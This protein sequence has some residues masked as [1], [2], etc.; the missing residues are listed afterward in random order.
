MQGGGGVDFDQGQ[1]PGDDAA[2]AADDA[3]EVAFG[4][5]GLV[6]G[7]PILDDEWGGGVEKEIEAAEK[8]EEGHHRNKDA[9]REGMTGLGEEEMCCGC[10]GGRIR[11]WGLVRERGFSWVYG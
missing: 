1:Q 3:H 4:V 7:F 11:L 9:G 2:G 10:H 5:H 6:G 8:D